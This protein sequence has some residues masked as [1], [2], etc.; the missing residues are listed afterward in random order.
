MPL[1]KPRSMAHNIRR[2][3]GAGESVQM[4]I[5]MASQTST[6]SLWLTLKL[7]V[8]RSQSPHKEQQHRKNTFS[9]LLAVS[10]LGSVVYSNPDSIHHQTWKAR[11]ILGTINQSTTISIVSKCNLPPS[12]VPGVLKFKAWFPFHLTTAHQ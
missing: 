5:S 2:G 3:D 11:K 4:P 9:L 6:K 8:S 1:C 12:T 10:L 7:S